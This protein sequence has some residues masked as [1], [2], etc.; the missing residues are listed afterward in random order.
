MENT[1][2]TVNTAQTDV[3]SS[4]PPLPPAWDQ[5]QQ[6]RRIHRERHEEVLDQFPQEDCSDDRQRH[7]DHERLD[8]ARLYGDVENEMNG[9]R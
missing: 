8:A 5:H 4:S 3:T 2:T 1:T 9:D 6:E 7:V